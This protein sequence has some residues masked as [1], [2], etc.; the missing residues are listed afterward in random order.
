MR[1]AKTRLEALETKAGGKLPPLILSYEGQY[2]ALKDG[3][4][5]GPGG[6]VYTADELEKL[7]EQYTVV[8]LS[9]GDWPPGHGGDNGDNFQLSWG[10]DEQNE[11]KI[12]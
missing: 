3:L 7:S 12:N 1:T 6:T 5:H 4:Y 8:V 9:W 2:G 10:D 11:R